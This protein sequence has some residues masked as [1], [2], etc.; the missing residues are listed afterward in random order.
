MLI[1]DSQVHIWHN[2]TMP[3]HHR[4]IATYSK[5]DLLKEM[6]EAGVDAALI[7]PPSFLG[8]ETNDLAWAAARQHPDR[9]AVMGWFELD[10][11]A[12]KETIKTWK[13]R[14]DNY[15]ARWAMMHESQRGWWKDG[16]LDWLW[17]AAEQAGIPLAF[18]VRDNMA[19][20]GAVAARYPHLKLTIDHI[21]RISGLRDD[22]AFATLPE[23]LA[24][25]KYP[26]VS[27]KLSGAPS[28]SSDPYPYKNIHGYLRQIFDAFGPKRC[29]WGTDI[30]RMPCSWR[31][32]ITMFTE[33]MPWLKGRDLEL[34]MGKALCEWIGWDL[35]RIR[36]QKR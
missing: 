12:S 13:A 16:T 1:V 34:V 15:G 3:N 36:A 26:N 28:Y 11:P 27:V 23:M 30:T 24:L 8:V 14:P 2:A 6:D 33:E 25:A 7:C 18:L 5:D 21:G 29:F 4:R 31:Q 35:E 17:P 22:T 10:N 20:L 19:E 32:C 9:L